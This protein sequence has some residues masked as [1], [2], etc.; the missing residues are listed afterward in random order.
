[1]NNSSRPSL[2]ALLGFLLF[3]I[4]QSTTCAQ[5][6][7]G[8]PALT[9]IKP[10]DWLHSKPI[11]AIPGLPFT[12]K[13]ELEMVSDVPGYQSTH[14]T[15][16]IVARD[17]KGR[18]R[19]ESRNWIDSAKGVDPLPTLIEIYDPT[20]KVRTD[21]Y[22][23]KKLAVGWVAGDKAP[24]KSPKSKDA[25]PKISAED[26]GTDTLQ[27]L[28]VHGVRI[29]KVLP[30]DLKFPHLTPEVIEY[31]YSDDLKINLLTK[32]SSSQFGVRT[33]RVTDLQRQEPDASL[34]AA[35]KD[36]KLQTEMASD[37]QA[38]LLG[39]LEEVAPPKC[40]RCPA[41]EYSDEAAR[42]R[43]QGV[44]Y[45]Q[46]VVNLQGRAEGIK[47][48]HAIGMGLDEQAVRAVKNWRFIP[49]QGPDGNPIPSSAPVELTFKFFASPLDTFH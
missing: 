7:T 9:E 14:S 48:V 4:S 37:P 13:V 31:W 41:P 42:A 20:S 8:T 6:Q 36:Y 2:A 15:Y 18:T 39:P 49:A 40:Q 22:P 17:S 5:A 28:P 27:G 44:V 47:V 25:Q 30:A 35:P 33:I 3:L 21:I 10:P 26:L 24:S 16:M 32:F 45:L 38:D 43:Y 34:M 11:P 23:E 46:I 1:M 19:N 12:A 29:H